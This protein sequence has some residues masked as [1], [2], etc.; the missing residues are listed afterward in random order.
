M[1][2][3]VIVVTTDDI[4]PTQEA[5]ETVRFSLDGVSYEIDLT[6]DN[7]KQLREALY[8]WIAPARVTARARGARR[9]V[10]PPPSHKVVPLPPS[11]AAVRAWALSRGIDVPPKGRIP[12]TVREQYAAEQSA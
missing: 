10:V 6:A 8:P 9:P 11:T 12:K 5:A 2:Q 4:D 7:A 3:R 1:A